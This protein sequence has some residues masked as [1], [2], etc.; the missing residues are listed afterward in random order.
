MNTQTIVL[1]LLKSGLTQTELAK[2]AGCAQPTISAF[3]LGVR[4]KRVSKEIGDRLFAL[5]A[6]RCREASGSP[7]V[8]TAASEVA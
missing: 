8:S 7:P 4:G 5:H 2:L 6:E 3:R 1:E